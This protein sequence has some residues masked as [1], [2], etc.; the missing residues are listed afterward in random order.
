V[1]EAGGA[2]R[3]W[4]DA[5]A[6]AA[7]AYA[8][9]ETIRAARITA[10]QEA[11]GC[12]D[13]ILR[14]AEADEAG[15]VRAAAAEIRARR[16]AA[17]RCGDALLDSLAAVVERLV[18]DGDGPGFGQ[19]ADALVLLSTEGR[20]NLVDR[21]VALA[22]AEAALDAPLFPAEAVDRA[23][24]ARVGQVEWEGPSHGGRP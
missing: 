13:E 24:A 16:T 23:R 8:I 22:S 6:R 4:L 1:I 9:G 21:H 17:R 5:R 15:L 12:R 11:T 2:R 7:E 20:A 10:E 3:R 14:A 19:D 18:V